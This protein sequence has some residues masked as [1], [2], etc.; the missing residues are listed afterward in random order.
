MRELLNVSDYPC[1]TDIVL[2]GDP[3][4]LRH[5]LE[6]FGFSGIELMLTGAGRE[7]FFSEFDICGVHLRFWPNWLDFWWGRE[8]ELVREFG[9]RETVAAVFGASREEW[10]SRWRENIRAAAACGARYVVL[11]V[12]NARSWELYN[13][14]FAYGAAT[15]ID[16]TADLVNAFADALPEECLLLYENLW[17]PG[18]T[19]T[20]PMLAAR[21]LEATRHERTGFLLDTGH[22]MNTELRL[23]DEAQAAAY[24]LRCV[25]NLGALRER[26]FAM[27]LHC[28]L[29]GAFVRRM[30]AQK[31]KERPQALTVE[32]SYRYVSQVDWHRPFATS[33]AR[34]IAEA[35][36]PEFLVHEFL[37]ESFAV[38]YDKVRQQK[39]SFGGGDA[40]V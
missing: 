23:A 10:L 9:D 26:I 8:E 37:Y 2:G 39:K 34:R 31:Q 36:E 11:H 30:M 12:A 1:D 4:R 16:A 28:S 15:V 14:R 38:W 40:A 20:E 21:L 22:M 24:I 6:E 7:E 29:S 33:A 32:E 25:K 19:L 35:V 17:W 18:L 27:H 13:R 5:L 3:T